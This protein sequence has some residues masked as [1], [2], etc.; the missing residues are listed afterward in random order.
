MSSSDCDG[1][2][3]VVAEVGDAGWLAAFGVNDAVAVLRLPMTGEL[4]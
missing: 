2:G 1:Q 4:P 3:S